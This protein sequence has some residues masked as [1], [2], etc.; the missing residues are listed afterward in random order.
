MYRLEHWK[1]FTAAETAGKKK[2]KSATNAVI[3]PNKAKK[4]REKEKGKEPTSGE[5]N[6]ANQEHSE[7]TTPNSTKPAIGMGEDGALRIRAEQIRRKSQHD[8]ERWRSG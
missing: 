3:H 6:T 5:A 8:D 7:S 4:D 1:A 2:I